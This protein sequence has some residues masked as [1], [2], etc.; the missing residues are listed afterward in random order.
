LRLLE[1]ERDEFPDHPFTLF[2]L[3]MTYRDARQ[4]DK[5]IGYLKRSIERSGEC[6]SHLRKAYA[7]VV[8]S[9]ALSGQSDSALQTCQEGLRIF[10]T[11]AEL[12]FLAG[13][14]LSDAGRYAEAADFYQKVLELPDDVQFAS[15]E[16]G[17]KGYL[18]RHN[19][20]V[21]YCNMGRLREAEEQLRLA[22]AEAPTFR[23]AIRAL[24]DVLIKQGKQTD[25]EALAHRLMKDDQLRSEGM[26]LQGQLS[27]V[28]GDLDAF[29]GDL[30][31]AV[32]QAPEDLDLLRTVC[33]ILCSRGDAE[34]AKGYLEDLVRHEPDD[35]S[36][37][38]D[39]G[40]VYL[41]TR[42]FAKSIE[43]LRESLRLRPDHPPT[44]LNLGFALKEHGQR[45][46]AMA[47]LSNLLRIAPYHACAVQAKQ[48][49]DSSKIALG[50]IHQA[51]V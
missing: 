37:H 36:A 28:R 34:T 32:R 17:I 33:Q 3:G 12:T 45:D 35:A 2:N 14:L 26:L 9:Y 24:G 50:L 7:L 8:S 25:V 13:G 6:E 18:T 42:D 23:P 22:I 10:P 1:L 27:A 41:Q 21:V 40:T 48:E 44:L 43:T 5:A 15:V 49:L 19:L 20:A 46:E 39:L 47:T 16:R 51:A 29:R 11:D 4:Y 31:E 38:H 30:A